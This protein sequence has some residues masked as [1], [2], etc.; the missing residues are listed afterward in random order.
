MHYNSIHFFI[1]VFKFFL[2]LYLQQYISKKYLYID[3]KPIRLG[4]GPVGLGCR[5]AYDRNKTYR[6]RSQ[7]YSYGSR[8]EYQNSSQYDSQQRI[9]RQIV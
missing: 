7:V 6:M 9:I 4:Q 1:F 5:S 3:T 2:K 8:I